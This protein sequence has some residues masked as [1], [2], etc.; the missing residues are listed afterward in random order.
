MT[1]VIGLLVTALFFGTLSNV[2][3]FFG[4]CSSTLGK[5]IYYFN[6]AGEI[7]F[8]CGKMD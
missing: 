8:I 4:L 1:T 3:S 7:N 2:L 5:K 6:S